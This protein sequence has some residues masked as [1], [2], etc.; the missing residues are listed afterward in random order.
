[1]IWEAPLLFFAGEILQKGK[2]QKNWK[3]S[4]KCDFEGFWLLEVRK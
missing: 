2:F 4:K 1:L 3:I